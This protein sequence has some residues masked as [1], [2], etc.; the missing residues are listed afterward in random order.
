MTMGT[1]KVSLLENF[2]QRI[3]SLR[4]KYFSGF[5]LGVCILLT[6]V[7]LIL[8]AH[9]SSK[10]YSLRPVFDGIKCSGPISSFQFSLP[11]SDLSSSS[12]PHYSGNNAT[13]VRES[14]EEKNRVEEE[15]VQ[16]KA[17]HGAQLGNSSGIER[18]PRTH[19]NAELLGGTASGNTHLGNL[20]VDA[21]NVSL[22]QNPDHLTEE[23]DVRGNGT[24]HRR[25]GAAADSSISTPTTGVL[26]L[27]A[28]EI[29]RALAAN[30]GSECD[31]FDGR[32]VRDDTMPYFPP[33]SCPFVDTS[34][35]CHLNGRPDN[36]Y[37]KWRWQPHGCDIPR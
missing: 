24:I 6:V 8:F 29:N 1:T 31:Y 2:P 20:D 27:T 22:T 25:V 16:Q 21:Q 5:G 35:D 19:E 9:S 11:C 28:E 37:L 32:W 4:R 12:S 15:D 36:G 17:P 3:L 23:Q 14:A 33:G 34:F 10:S 26:G 13:G 7:T 18:S 30:H